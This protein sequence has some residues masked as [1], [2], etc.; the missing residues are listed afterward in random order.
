MTKIASRGGGSCL[1][2]Q[3]VDV[4]V[5]EF[6]LRLS[7]GI[8]IMHIILWFFFFLI[9]SDPVLR[10][11]C[12]HWD[13]VLL[14][15]VMWTLSPPL[16]HQGLPMCADL[17]C[18]Q[19][20]AIDIHENACALTQVPTT[21]VFRGSSFTS[22]HVTLEYSLTLGPPVDTAFTWR[23]TTNC[24]ILCRRAPRLER[25][26]RRFQLSSHT[27][28]TSGPCSSALCLGA[29]ENVPKKQHEQTSLP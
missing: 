3:P 21:Q 18:P 17:Q 4:Q 13:L 8:K 14:H 23:A 15:C 25:Q 11:H 2:T 7:L 22:Y 9:D 1:K 6:Y 28:F 24:H 20:L 12:R 29:G 26:S 19:F 27:C 16:V 10:Y 5:T